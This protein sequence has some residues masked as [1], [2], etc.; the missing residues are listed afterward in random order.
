MLSIYQTFQ[1]LPFWIQITA[2]T[3]LCDYV[4]GFKLH[5]KKFPTIGLD[6]FYLYASPCFLQKILIVIS[7]SWVVHHCRKS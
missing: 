5:Q 2:T 3:T 1:A 4:K 6:I 7:A